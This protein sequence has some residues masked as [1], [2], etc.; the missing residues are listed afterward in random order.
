MHMVAWV[1]SG[2]SSMVASL[3]GV[4]LRY[5]KLRLDPKVGLMDSTFIARF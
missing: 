1:C 3:K 4:S 2:G 5:R